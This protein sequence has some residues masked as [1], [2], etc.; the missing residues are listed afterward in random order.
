MPLIMELCW[1]NSAG[2]LVFPGATAALAACPQV[3]LGLLEGYEVVAARDEGFRIAAQDNPSNPQGM[4][5][6]KWLNLPSWAPC[7]GQ[8]DIY[9]TKVS[10]VA[11]FNATN[12]SIV[13]WTEWATTMPFPP[14]PAVCLNSAELSNVVW[15]AVEIISNQTVGSAV[16]WRGRRIRGARIGGVV[17]ADRGILIRM[18]STRYI[19]GWKG[20]P[21]T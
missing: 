18:W 20:A 15:H 8:Y 19:C 2:V 21:A 5:F 11:E 3:P 10:G 12:C 7:A 4:I 6:I 14:Q 1:T 13:G 17:R 9:G 16:G